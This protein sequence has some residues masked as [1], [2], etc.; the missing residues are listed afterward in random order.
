VGYEAVRQL[1]ALDENSIDNAVASCTGRS[2]DG[3]SSSSA[4]G[5]LAVVAIAFVGIVV[6]L[7]FA[8]CFYRSV[9]KN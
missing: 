5:I 7:G 4:I 8:Y 6:V 9:H 3:I 1:W 2:S